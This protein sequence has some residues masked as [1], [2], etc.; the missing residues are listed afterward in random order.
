MDRDTRRALK[1]IRSIT[2][3]GA[4]SEAMRGIQECQ[5][6]IR[7]SDITEMTRALHLSSASEVLRQQHLLA[8]HA[9][10]SPTRETLRTLQYAS[11]WNQLADASR[12]LGEGSSA[13]SVVRKASEHLA[14]ELRSRG[15]PLLGSRGACDSH[16]PQRQSHG[17]LRQSGQDDSTESQNRVPLARQPATQSPIERLSKA[18]RRPDVHDYAITSAS[19]KHRGPITKEEY[20]TLVRERHRYDFIIDGISAQCYKRSDSAH[21]H[22]QAHLTV[23]ELELVRD[24]I[25]MGGIYSPRRFRRH[26][27]SI[28]PE[29]A[30]RLFNSMRQKVDV[31]IGRGVYTLFHTR[32]GRTGRLRAFEFDPPDSVSWLLI[33]SPTMQGSAE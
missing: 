29:T 18:L 11:R 15:L 31:E 4:F 12:A 6:I 14:D 24:Y 16:G 32:K 1:V 2:G 3:S 13:R 27:G 10:S 25:V 5:N 33:E 28:E 19:D 26:A 20:E 7:Q 8:R 23:S 30:I 17:L 9:L 22:R 21:K